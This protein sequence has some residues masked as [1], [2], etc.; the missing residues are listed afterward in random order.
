MMFQGHSFLKILGNGVVVTQAPGMG[1]AS[2]VT[3]FSNG[4]AMRQE[5]E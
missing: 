5:I 3:V 4:A 2:I 1:D